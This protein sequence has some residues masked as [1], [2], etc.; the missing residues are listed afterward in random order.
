MSNGPGQFNY[1]VAIIGGGSAG[2]AA[3]RTSAGHGLK[4]VVIDGAKELGGLCILRGCMPTK[5]LLYASEVLHL[6]KNS[7]SFG[8]RSGGV[9]PDFALVMQRKNRLIREFANYR[10]EQLEK[11]RFDLIRSQAEFLDPNRVQLTEGKTISAKSF[12]LATGSVI[13]PSPLDALDKVG[14]LTSDE[15]LALEKLPKSLVVLGGGAVAVEFA[16]FFNRMGVSVTLIQRSEH[17]LK[18]EDNDAGMVIEEAFRKEGMTVFTGTK[19]LNAER[20][21]ELK[22]VT[23]EHGGQTIR[24]AAE[25]ILYALGRIPNVHGLKLDKAG[26]RLA[27]GG[28]LTNSAMQTS[29]PHIYGAGDCTGMHE[30]VHIAIQQ[31]EIAAHNIA[32]PEKLKAMDYRLLISV[33]FTEPQIGRVGLTEKQA[34]AQ[35]IPYLA[36]SYPFNDHGKSMIME[37]LHGFVKLLADPK[38]G[39]IL[40][41]CCVGPSGGELIHEIVAAMQKRMT[42]H[43]LAVMPHYHPTL[44]EIWTY[45]AEEL[46][47]KITL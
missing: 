41:G 1:E 20:E 36:A 23:F 12:I 11:G 28:L 43:E 2:Y 13:S 45:P 46:A 14:Y 47:S 34:V 7:I 39:E 6:A 21:G 38:T 19:L 30:I 3:A 16:Q 17:I 26:V 33:V 42:V 35:K 10:V 5:A 15:A 29:A 44:A 27:Y 37:A 18:E 22:V 25:E 32:H 24:I 40:G 9:E 8:I 31:G 4:T